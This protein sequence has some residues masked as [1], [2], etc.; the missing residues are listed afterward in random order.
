MS[1][2][3]VPADEEE[4]IDERTRMKQPEE[5][6]AERHH[7]LQLQT[8]HTSPDL[9][10]RLL[11]TYY[12]ARTYLEEQ[13]V[14]VLYLVLGMLNWYEDDNSKTERQ[15][16]LILIPVEL[17]RTSVHARF[18]LHYTGEEVGDN[19]SLR[20]K[21]KIDFGLELPILPQGEELDIHAYLSEVQKALLSESRWTVDSS[22]IALGFFSFGTFLMYN[23]LDLANWPEEIDP[24]N[25]PLLQAVLQQG[26][27]ELPPE[28]GDDELIDK[29]VSP[30]DSYQVVDADS[31][32][33][34]AILDVNQGRNLVVQGPPGTGKSQTITNLIAEALSHDKKVLFVAEKMAA[35][36]VV[37]RRLDDVGLGAA[38]LELHS[39]K[40]SKKAFLEELEHTLQL[41]R[42]RLSDYSG[43][44][45]ALVESRDRLNEYSQAVNTPITTSG[46]TPY[47]AY[48]R[49]LKL[50]DQ[51]KGIKTPTLDAQPMVDWS[52]PVYRQRLEQ[53]TAFEASLKQMGLPVQHPFWGSGY[54][55]YLPTDRRQ[56]RAACESVENALDSLLEA[57][58][59]LA[60]HLGTEI[61]T[62]RED[63]IRLSQA[64]KMLRTAPLLKGVAVQNDVWLQQTAALKQVA[65][66]GARLAE[67]REIHGTYLLPEAW[68]QDVLEI[69]AAYMN[70]SNRWWRF[71]I[72][73]FRRAKG[74]LAGMTQ[75]GLPK[76][77]ESQQALIEAIL[78]VQHLRP[79][80][81]SEA[82]LLTQLYGTLYEAEKTDWEQVM[83]VTDWL[84]TFHQQVKAG[85]YPPAVLSYLNDGRLDQDH[86]P[87]L[88]STLENTL[89][90]HGEA[91]LALVEQL[92]LNEAFRFGEGGRFGTIPFVR[93]RQLLE[94]WHLN[95]DRL[96]EIVTYNHHARLMK[97]YNLDSV[98]A[99]SADWQEADRYLSL[100]FQRTW[101][102]MLLDQ[103]M[104]ERSSLAVFNRATQHYRIQRFREIDELTFTINRVQLAHHHW[105]QLPRHSTGRGQLGIL[106]REFAKKRRHLPIRQLILQAGHAVQALKPVFMMSPLSIAQFLPPGSLE[107]DLV[108][109]DEASQVRPIEAL[110]ALLRA[111]QAVVVGDSKQLPPTNFFN[112]IVEPEDGQ[113]SATG[114]L[115]SVLSLFLAQGAPQRMLRWHY[116]SQHES[117]IAVS[118]YE[119]YDNRLVLFPSPDAE[120]RS[121]GLV[122]HHLPHSVYDRGGSRSNQI[123][124]KTVA[125]WVMKHAHTRSELTLGVAAFSVN[126]MQAIQDQ[127]ELLRRKDPTCEHFFNS[128]PHE[129][130]FV[131]NLENVQ[132][133]ERDII[134]ISIGYGRDQHGT[135]SMNFGPLNNE[136]GERRLNVL[137]TRARLRCEIFTN[138][139]DDDIDLNRSNTRG[140]VAL[141]RYLKYARTGEL[142]VSEP[143]EGEAESPFEEA[144][145]D[146]LRQQGYDVVHQVG[147]SG[148]RID[149]AIKDPQHPGRYLLGIECDGATYHSAR[150][151]RDRDRLRQQV[152]ERMGWTIH[153]IWST[154]WFRMPGRELRRTVEAIEAAKAWSPV[155]DRTPLS[156]PLPDICNGDPIERFK[157]QDKPTKLK[158]EPYQIARLRLPYNTPL[159][160][161]PSTQ[162]ASWIKQVVDVEGPIHLEEAARRVLEASD[163]NR[164]GNRIRTAIDQGI[165]RALAGKKIKRRGDFLWSVNRDSLTAVRSHAHLP[166]YNRSLDRIAPEEIALAIELTVQSTFGLPRD[167][168]PAAVCNLLG[169]GR[170]SQAMKN[171]VDALVTQ[172]LA[173]SRLSKKG[174]FLVVEEQNT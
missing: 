10:K 118:N 157:P 32:Q 138:I 134:F 174:E 131:K 169:F 42:P 61:P 67:L 9:Q 86:L 5:T 64:G 116:R 19:L 69:R 92:Q 85:N 163:Y 120:R 35:L 26:F 52:G 107:F 55:S 25:H 47:Q 37:K 31:S 98:V 63:A 73:E 36:E 72:P 171:Q 3:S 166:N 99:V 141:K 45:Q 100:L 84:V 137:T 124:A 121:L 74:R 160:E 143:T 89:D 142:E 78:E 88:V 173:N 24:A 27:Q 7:D 13:G 161:L 54:T 119:F 113:E 159:H 144:V 91:C 8:P 70:H 94:R 128:H 147:A 75:T 51:L 132:G 14:N 156:P 30:E 146:A 105:E 48:G 111:K 117:L 29:Y 2:L 104:Q 28:V 20:T 11:N 155:L 1:F 153:R 60:R 33:M 49:L 122:L 115:E 172:M 43:D 57:A 140:I 6:A 15:G 82:P 114:D 139:T 149:L 80:V 4:Q 130:F 22:A 87:S 152:L 148:F 101:Y 12:T 21:L 168:I 71:L 41:G 16:P 66:Q 59:H 56:I 95:V 46:V 44:L 103:A 96:Q 125:Q 34:L 106:Q 50:Q 165:R 154:D 129:P 123:E 170:T 40:T 38:C 109:F 167:E 136:G 17:T 150:S 79:Q 81:E 110:G 68:E 23:D 164:M 90:V 77:I 145:A 83:E 102:E 62:T 135:V 76:E 133:D 53:V 65:V 39:H 126:Q 162:I 108:V 151:A 158:A 112:Q 127:L 93:Q 58:T 18:H 97:Q